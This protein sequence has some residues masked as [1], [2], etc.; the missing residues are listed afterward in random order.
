MTNTRR[1]AF[2]IPD[3]LYR[4]ALELAKERNETLSDVVRAGLERYVKRGRKK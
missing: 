3:E 1:H 4:E 2:R